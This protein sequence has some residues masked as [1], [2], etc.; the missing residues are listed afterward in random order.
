MPL[1]SLNLHEIKEQFNSLVPIARELGYN[2]KPWT[3]LPQDRDYGM[4]RL[5]WLRNK[6][7]LPAIETAETV[8][9]DLGARLPLRYLQNEWNRLVPDAVAQGIRVRE[10]TIVP[11]T[12]RHGLRRLAWLKEKMAANAAR[13]AVVDGRLM[14]VEDIELFGTKTFGVEIECYMPIGMT[15][16]SLAAL[17]RQAGVNINAEVY[18]HAVRPSWKIVTDGS[19]GDL[20][21]GVE[22]VSPKL[23]GAEGFSDLVK[24][25]NVLTAQRCKVSRKCGLHVHV[26]VRAETA[27]TVRRVAENYSWYQD[28][29][30]KFL[31]P[32]RTNNQYAHNLSGTSSFRQ[33]NS[34]REVILSVGQDA[35]NPRSHRRYRVVNFQQLNNYGTVEFRQHQGSVEADKIVNWVKFCMRFVIASRSASALSSRAPAALDNLMDM[36]GMQG[37]A[38]AY[39]V[40]RTEHFARGLDDRLDAM[41]RTSQPS[42]S[43]VYPNG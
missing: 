36:I 26:D 20:S 27:Q 5:N 38:R 7:G 29:I 21:R 24:V 16:S 40:A 33:C 43:H 37:E 18:N 22:I 32:S 34:F 41:R 17:I 4:Q 15:A 30:N 39:F 23:A 25:C 8:R 10:W 6:C 31:A 3:A 11:T 19:L 35:D 12:A 14:I 1:Q 42:I 13:I 2:V 9:T 28:V